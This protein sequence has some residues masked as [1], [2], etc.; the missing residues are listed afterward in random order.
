M[1]R[2]LLFAVTIF[3]SSFLLFQ[4]QPLIGKH[5]LPWFGGSPAVWITAMFFFMTALAV[6]YVYA[7]IL[8]KL[9]L[10]YQA[11]FHLVVVILVVAFIKDHAALWTSAIT[12]AFESLSLDVAKPT[13]SVLEVLFVTIGLPFALLSS[14]SSLLQLWYGKI[15]GQEPFSLYGISNIGSL[16]GLLSYPLFFERFYSTYE[17]GEWWT[18]GFLLYVALL[19]FVLYTLLLSH[20]HSTKVAVRSKKEV[21][22]SKKDYLVWAGITAVPVAVMLSGTVFMTTIIAPVPFLWAG[23]LALYLLSFAISFREG[24]RLPKWTNELL[25]VMLSLFA[26][27]VAVSVGKVIILSVLVMHL[28]LFA[29]YHWCHEELYS[30]RPSAVYLTEYYVALAFGGILGSLVIELSS[31]YLLSIPIELLLILCGSLFFI[32]YKWWQ[33]KDL[34]LPIASRFQLRLLSGIAMGGMVLVLIITVYDFQKSTLT[35]ERNFFGYKAIVEHNI[36]DTKKTIILQHGKTNHGFQVFINDE[37]IAIPTSYYGTSSG[38]GRV[39]TAK[40]ND[41]NSEDGEGLKVAVAGLGSGSI[42]A[43]CEPDD[44]ITVFEI[45]PE[46]IKM[47]EDNF[48]F[49]EQCPNA[50]VK[51]TDAR[52]GLREIEKEAGEQQYDMIIV[53]AYADDVVP[54]H[55]MTVEAVALYKSLLKDD[56]VLSIHVSSR[57]LDLLPV[58]RGVGRE[59]DMVTRYYN[60]SEPQNEDSTAS[61]WTILAKDTSILA[62]ENLRNVSDFSDVE[63]EILWTDTFSALWPVI[64]W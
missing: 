50:V 53:D 59:N 47:A 31:N 44:E 24:V 56:G 13:W 22:P 39:F 64:R 6:G 34:Y 29:V 46:V 15:S 8:S 20:K 27:Y 10:W 9:R 51:L 25:V 45:D 54:M 55:L 17:Q 43:Y 30:R 48:T 57:Y 14:T 41:K 4:V 58:V 16:L 21:P 40:R 1:F 26:L 28:A 42:L 7:L 49:L 35:Q 18:Y 11:I 23:P 60:D 3:L 36:S 5:I 62:D 19:L 61:I 63:K 37:P 32:S 2:Y 33:Q 38:I 52:L 12:P